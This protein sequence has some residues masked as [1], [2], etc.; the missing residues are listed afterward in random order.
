MIDV[1]APVLKV[2]VQVSE[3]G[4]RLWVNIDGACVLRV[5]EMK[6]DTLVIHDDRIK[7]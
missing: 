4:K 7:G 6:P 5:Q 1:R 3:D 2:E